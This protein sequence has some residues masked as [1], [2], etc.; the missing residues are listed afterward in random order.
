MEAA[1]ALLEEEEWKECKDSQ[2]V[3]LGSGRFCIART[4]N[5]RSS[6]GDTDK[7]ITKDITVLTGVELLPSVQ[8]ASGDNGEVEL[9][10][11]PHKSLYYKS[12]GNTVDAVF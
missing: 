10:M 2:L 9:Q 7:D 4:L 11:I 5:A 8:D 12:D 3:N 1:F 6:V